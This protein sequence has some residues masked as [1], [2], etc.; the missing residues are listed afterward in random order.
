MPNPS[1]YLVMGLDSPGLGVPAG[2]QL[3]LIEYQ[4]LG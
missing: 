4:A 2:E 1:M 3:L